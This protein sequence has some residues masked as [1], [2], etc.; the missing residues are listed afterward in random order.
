MP[1]S[2]LADAHAVAL[3]KGSSERHERRYPRPTI[4]IFKPS[5]G[6]FLDDGPAFTPDRRHII[7][8]RCCQPEVPTGFSLWEVNI[9]GHNLKPVTDEAVPSND[10][11]SDNLPQVAPN[12]LDV[13]YHRNVRPC[14]MGG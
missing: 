5:E 10:G 8:T 11:P 13:A 12:G 2:E 7:F 9:D 6:T 1:L 3:A 4:T 14:D